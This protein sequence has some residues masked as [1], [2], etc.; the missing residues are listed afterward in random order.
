M[1][2]ITSGARIS[3]WYKDVQP[4]ATEPLGNRQL[5]ADVCVIGGG[6]AGVSS[7]YMLQREGKSV[8]LLEDGFIGS[9]ETGRT[10]AHLMSA[11]D[12][13]FYEIQKL[14]G[15]DD[16]I[17]A[18]E[19]HRAAIDTIEEFVKTENIDCE[20][21]RITGYLFAPSAH[22]VSVKERNEH[23]DLI[24][25][26]HTA[27][28]ESSVENKLVEKAPI[29]N[30]DTGMC[31]E[32]PNQGE[33][34]PLKY[35]NGLTQAFIRRGGKV[36]TGTHADEVKGGSNAYVTTV[37]GGKIQCDH[38]V[39]ATNTPVNDRV[40]MHTKQE[41][42]RSY[43]VC[44]TLPKGSVAKAL[45]WDTLDPYHYVR[46]TNF[47][48][49]EDLLIVGGAD[50]KTGQADD[51]EAPFKDLYQWAKDRWPMISDKIQY[52]WSGQVWEPV[53]LLGFLGHNPHDHDNVYIITGDSGT[54]MTHTTIGGRIITDMIMGRKNPWASLYDPSRL[55]ITSDLIKGNLNVGAQY[56]KWCSG[57]EVPDIEDISYGNGAVMLKG[58]HY[59]AVYRDEKGIFHEMSAVCPHLKG[60]I[61]WN[62]AEKTWDCPC[63]GSRFDRFGKVVTGPSNEDL[64]PCNVILKER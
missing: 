8:V 29:W 55:K 2:D 59:V 61:R 3:C 19:S 23:L 6:L 38:I 51:Y 58:L 60:I 18:G 25:K 21:T 17:R 44:C 12:D 34:H 27:A 14:F 32:F 57:S 20:F 13:R 24:R 63:H 48:E 37:G 16:S 15:K 46:T 31:L 47:S 39:M 22:E 49:T 35:L 11:L 40:T 56:L 42:Y 43:V 26:E 52:A 9:G 33:F 45:F 4:F 50:H 54:G 41:P 28:I 36:F 30:F 64:H 10:T 7:A 62:P 5:K 53:D 1:S